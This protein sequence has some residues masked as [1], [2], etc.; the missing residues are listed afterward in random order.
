META[1]DPLDCSDADEFLLE[2]MAIMEY[3]GGMKRSD[4]ELHAMAAT[5]RYCERTGATELRDSRYRVYMQLFARHGMPVLPETPAVMTV[6]EIADRLD[7]SLYYLHRSVIDAG[8]L[9]V[10]QG[11]DGELV[12]D[13]LAAERYIAAQN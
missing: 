8:K 9:A 2:R 7:V 3:D 1:F 5:L 10:T 11:A 13:R 6:A 4:A 12:V